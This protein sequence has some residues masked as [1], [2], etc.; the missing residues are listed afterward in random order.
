MKGQLIRDYPGH[1]KK[2]IEL[3]NK[4]WEALDQLTETAAVK[5][6]LDIAVREH[7]DAVLDRIQGQKEQISGQLASMEKANENQKQRFHEL[8]KAAAL[9]SQIDREELL[10]LQSDISS[11]DMRKAAI[12]AAA[13][14]IRASEEER[15]EHNSIVVGISGGSDLYHELHVRMDKVHAL[16]VQIRAEAERLKYNS[17]FLALNYELTRQPLSEAEWGLFQPP[18]KT[19]EELPGEFDDEEIE[20]N[21]GGGTEWF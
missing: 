1:K 16:A 18:Q 8:M 15:E 21:D 4:L 7:A 20:I 19:A 17:D 14:D 10:R 2:L 9:G 12:E 5:R 11:Y 13:R 6:D 3:T